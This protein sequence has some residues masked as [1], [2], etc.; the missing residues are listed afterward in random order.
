MRANF[1]VMSLNDAYDYTDKLKELLSKSG[2]VLEVSKEFKEISENSDR[3]K[4]VQN[5]LLTHG[6]IAEGKLKLDK[7]NAVAESCRTKGNQ[8]YTKKQFLDALESYNK[9]LCFAESGSETIGMAYANRSAVFFELRLFDNCLDNI[10]HAKQNGYP[11]DQLHKLQKREEMC[12]AMINNKE[13]LVGAGEPVGAEFFK[14]TRKVSEKVPFIADC[15]E[16]KSSEKFGRYITTKAALNPGEIICIEDPFTKFLLSNHRYKYC[17]TCLGDNFLDLFSCPSCTST[18]FC[19][20]ECQRHGEEKFHKYECPVIDKLNSLAKKI[21]RIAARSFFEALDACGG[22]LQELKALV[23]ENEGS[24]KTVF[25][26]DSPME[27]KN[28]LIAVDALAANEMQRSHADLF[29]RAGIVAVVSQLLMNHTS[30]K[31]LLTT[32]DDQDFFNCFVFKQTQIAACNYHGLYNGLSKAW[33]VESNEQYG[34]GSFPFL[35]LI[36]HSCAPN[37]VRVTYGCKNYVVVNR[38]I[39][40][41]EQLFDNYGFHHCLEDL[42]ERQ[43]SLFSQ[44]MFKCSCEACK[45]NFPLFPYLPLVDQGFQKFISNDI[46]KLSLLDVKTAKE[47][48]PA[49]CNYLKKFDRKYPCYEISSV[50]E[51]LLRCFTIFTM[52]EFKLKLCAK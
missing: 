7:S 33:E 30:L 25:D 45:R 3:I 52:S 42:R 44:Y 15:L 20:V 13:S 10:E 37:L 24:S 6:L 46:K 36:N 28:V 51:C 18:M 1:V 31:D 5:L 40:P 9:S 41:G 43:T 12:N 48:F 49:Y 34:S 27:R 35:S 21:L 23:K 22:D 26:F 2:K 16:L 32:A 39:A 50:Q 11:S 14:I 17:A 38:P 4:Y 47:R 8:F 29:Q 19:S